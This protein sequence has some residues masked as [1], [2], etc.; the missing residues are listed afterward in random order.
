MIE[1]LA[2]LFEQKDISILDISWLIDELEAFTYIY[3]AN[4]RNV[5]Y[6]APQ[7]VHDDSVISLSL[8]IQSRKHLSLGKTASDFR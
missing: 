2:V 3:N 5:Q 7:G 4:T 1:D 6:S 8:A